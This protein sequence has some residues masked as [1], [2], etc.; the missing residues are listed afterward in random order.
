MAPDYPTAL[1]LLLLAGMFDITFTSMAQTLVQVLAPPR[2]RGRVVGVFTTAALGLRAG[3]GVTVG[4]LGAMIGVRVSLALGAAAVVLVASGSSSGRGGL[5]RPDVRNPE[6]LG[7][8]E[9]TSHPE[10]GGRPWSS[11]VRSERSVTSS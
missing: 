6:H 11:R 7:Y 10:R 1:I 4:L 8:P 9:P 2:V 5:G 3:S